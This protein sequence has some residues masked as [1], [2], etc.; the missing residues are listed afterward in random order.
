MY[1]VWVKPAYFTRLLELCLPSLE[2]IFLI[3]EEGFTG[4]G[5]VLKGPA[6]PD[7]NL[8]AVAETM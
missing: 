1:P 4:W 3:F 5:T 8:V 6:G 2:I 7:G